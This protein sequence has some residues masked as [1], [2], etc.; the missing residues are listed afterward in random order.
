MV[1]ETAIAVWPPDLAAV[2]IAPPVKFQADF[3]PVRDWPVFGLRPLELAALRFI[4]YE[5]P[6]SMA[7]FKRKFRRGTPKA[8]SDALHDLS[9]LGM[10]RIIV[11]RDGAF[12]LQVTATPDYDEL[13]RTAYA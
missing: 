6:V 8:R 9:R 12:W 5:G 11:D 2:V 1:C 3:K 4:D 7:D 13:E 10:V